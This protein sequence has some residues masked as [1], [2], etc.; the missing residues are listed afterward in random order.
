VGNFN[1]P[2]STIDVSWKQKLNRNTVKLTEVMNQIDLTNIYKHFILKHKEYTF[3]S[4]LNGTFSKT[5]HIIGHKTA[6]NRYKHPIRS[7]RLRLVLN[8]NKNKEKHTY[9]W[10]L[11]NVL[12]IDNVVQ[13]E[14][15]KEIK[16]F[17]EDEE[18]EDTS[19]QN[20]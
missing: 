20:L 15:K 17:L 2:L 5:D 12:L 6:L 4:E 9:T 19:Y 8:T 10:K 18:N 11:K 16:G 1:T 3:L 13:E 7:P 14:I